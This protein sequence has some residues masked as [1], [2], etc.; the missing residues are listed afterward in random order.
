MQLTTLCDNLTKRIEDSPLTPQ[1][2]NHGDVEWRVYR[3][4]SV[5]VLLT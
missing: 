3:S 4:P 2:S 5:D 1:G